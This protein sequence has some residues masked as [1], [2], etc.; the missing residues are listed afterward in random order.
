ML[1]PVQGN[2]GRTPL[3]HPRKGDMRL[4][5][6][7]AAYIFDVPDLPLKLSILLD[8]GSAAKGL[9]TGSTHSRV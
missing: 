1:G 2:H 6:N 7:G 9:D 3:L 8:V 5:V 4:M